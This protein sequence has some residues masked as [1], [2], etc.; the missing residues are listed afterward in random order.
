[1]TELAFSP[2]GR[3]LTAATARNMVTVWDADSRSLLRG[4][5][6]NPGGV[7][8][9]AAISG[10]GSMLASSYGDGVR[11]WSLSTGAML[12]RLGDAGAGSSIVF[13]P[14]ERNLAF[15]R[16][17]GTVPVGASRSEIEIWDAPRHSLVRTIA[18]DG[19]SPTGWALAFSPDGRTLAIGGLDPVVRLWNMDDGRLVREFEHNVGRTVWALEFSPDGSVLA[20]S[21]GDGFASLRD[22]ATGRQ[23]GPRLGIG[24]RE[25]MLD[26]S[27][28][29]RK[30]LMTHG[31][32]K[33]AIWT[34]DAASWLERACSLANRTL[35]RE[36]W[37]EFLPGRPYEPACR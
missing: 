32:G 13:S 5:F 9:S 6:A 20:V 28:D 37:D 36:E 29:G 8:L 14:T 3:T 19:Y 25:A 30:L 34:I 4:P 15:V 2:D 22:V 35:T 10:D 31:D 23:I 16:D 17:E 21:G 12:G 11:L 18:F 26:L 1:V 24:S 33:A 7:S 27:S